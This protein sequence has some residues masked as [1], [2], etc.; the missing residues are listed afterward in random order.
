MTAQSL[1][2][3]QNVVTIPNASATVSGVVNTGAQTFAGAKTWNAAQTCN[4]T[5]SAVQ[6]YTA[7][8]SQGG[9]GITNG[10]SITTTYVIPNGA[11]VQ[12]FI[13]NLVGVNQVG[14]SGYFL[15]ARS[16]TGLISTTV[17]ASGYA[18]T[19]SGNS[20]VVTNNTGGTKYFTVSFF[21]VI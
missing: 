14:D 1:K 21:R 2:A 16:G 5:M 7:V 3:R 13:A 9:G 8:D 11:V 18:I 6:F 15:V 17:L 20:I 4:S 12:V 19:F 10:G